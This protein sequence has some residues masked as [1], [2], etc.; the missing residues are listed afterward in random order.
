MERFTHLVDRIYHCA[1]DDSAWPE[2][3]S[4]FAAAFDTASTVFQLRDL[5]NG[6]IRIL[7]RTANA[8][9]N[10]DLAYRTHHHRLDVWT[11][12]GARLAPMTVMN[13][14]QVISTK[15]FA[16]SEIYCNFF[17]PLGIFHV[18]GAAFPVSADQLG[19]MGVHRDRDQTQFD[20]DAER[21]LSALLPHLQRSLQLRRHLTPDA[22]PNPHDA[23]LCTLVVDA[24]M[25]I[26][27]SS[28]AADDLLRHGDGLYLANGMIAS[29]SPDTTAALTRHVANAVGTMAARHGEPG[30]LVSV[31]RLHGFPLTVQIAPFAFKRNVQGDS[32]PA[33]M[34]IVRDPERMPS[35]FAKSVE[36][37]FGLTRAEALIA[38]GLA[39]G[40]AVQE[41][42]IANGVTYHTAR[43]QLKT[44][45]RKT[46][47]SRQ[48][49]VIALLLKSLPV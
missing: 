13:G 10:A 18:I 27:R 28:V 30:G 41:I 21:R 29:Y 32:A 5:S 9:A 6:G 22:S 23:Q 11:E 26:L 44:L 16:A 14:E 43:T 37:I 2:L 4:T 49:E 46:G 36:T 20:A 15:D 19:I 12:K 1:F 40:L 25:R 39:R 31:P 17:R 8:N 38:E 35:D 33:A 48:G 42:A 3:A 24:N 45:M 47:T 34:L 7:G